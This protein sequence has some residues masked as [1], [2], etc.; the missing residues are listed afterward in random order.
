MEQS[1]K[2]E[3]IPPFDF[4]WACLFRRTAVVFDAVFESAFDLR[5]VCDG[6]RRG[7][8]VGGFE[9]E[10]AFAD[11]FVFEVE[12][13]LLQTQVEVQVVP[14]YLVLGLELARA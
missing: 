11:E 3:A 5:D 14:L 9:L 6:F 2:P 10:V 4:A 1:G 12:E 7:F 8:G 13:V